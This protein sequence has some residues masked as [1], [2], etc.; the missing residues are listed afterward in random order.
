MNKNS[1][2]RETGDVTDPP[3][4]LAICSFEEKPINSGLQED[5]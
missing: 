2:K 4:Q 1:E 3:L 5:V